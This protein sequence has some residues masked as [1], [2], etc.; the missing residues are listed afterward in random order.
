M[1]FFKGNGGEKIHTDNMT[2]AW[3]C[4][5]T[6]LVILDDDVLSPMRRKG[7]LHPLHRQLEGG[8]SHARVALRRGVHARKGVAHVT[9]ELRLHV[10]RRPG[11]LLVQ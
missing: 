9:A 5:D 4:W 11:M 1:D 2:V 7:G 3:R 6:F 10:L 8:P